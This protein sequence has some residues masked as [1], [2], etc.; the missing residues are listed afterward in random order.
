M[1]DCPL[2]IILV[3]PVWNDSV[4]LARF[5]PRLAGEL[6]ASGLPVTW[7]ISDDGSSQSERLALG[8]LLAKLRPLYPRIGLHFLP[9]RSRKGG[10]VRAAW[11]LYPDADWLAFID[12]DGAIAADVMIGLIRQAIAMGTGS[13]V[14]AVRRDSSLTPVRRSRLR[15]FCFRAFRW[16]ER[17]VLPLPFE[18][19]QCG[20]KVVSGQDWRELAPL[21]RENGFAFDAE[22]LLA[23]ALNRRKIIEEPVP[24]TEQACGRV[25]LLRDALPML[26]AL[27]RISIRAKAGRYAVAP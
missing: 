12:A 11:E 9:Q 26:A 14:V 19:T 15:H 17:L 18:D 16:F 13:T 24:W 5:G 10:A 6:A 22:L 23:L 2:E 8:A 27:G 7:V 21:I 25:R 4:R 1:Q 20:A 3:T